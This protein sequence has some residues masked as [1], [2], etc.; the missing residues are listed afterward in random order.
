[1]KQ[2]N[3]RKFEFLVA[4]EQ[5]IAHTK[6]FFFPVLSA[7]TCIDNHLGVDQRRVHVPRRDSFMKA[8]TSVDAI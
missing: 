2:E 1:M 6:L 5:E 8:D 7:A 4:G 3:A